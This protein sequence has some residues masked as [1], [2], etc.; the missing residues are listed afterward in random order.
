MKTGW[1][2]MLALV[3]SV[4]F[5]I[6][7]QAAG[8]QARGPT[9][10]QVLEKTG[11]YVTA[12]QREFAGVVVEEAYVQH[13]ATGSRFD[14]LGHLLRGN[15][16]DRELKS[17]LL[18]VRPE[19]SNRWLQ[20]RDVYEVDGRT[21]RDRSDRLAKL[22][23]Q[24]SSSTSKQVSKINEESSRY[25]IGSI[26]RNVNVPMLALAV[27][28][29]E[30]Q[31]RFVFNHVEQPD[32]PLGADAWKIA[33]REMAS[34]TMIRGAGDQDMPVEGFFLVDAATGRVRFTS[35][36][37]QNRTVRAKIDVA[38]AEDAKLGLFAPQEMTESYT[39]SAD[40]A[41]VEGH[42]TYSNPRRFQVKVDEKIAPIIK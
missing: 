33:F 38:Y 16:K 32:S 3:A 13:A 31:Y 17:D 37:A 34:G 30:N 22:F 40:G 6:R 20:F 26:I 5:A 25:N 28:I 19:G 36:I 10:E 39:Q 21:V 12:Y 14:S 4:A 9:L 42:A 15:T 27:L 41:T 11:D 35:L 18:L 8:E 24:P 23:L 2:L 1:W 7:T 29:P